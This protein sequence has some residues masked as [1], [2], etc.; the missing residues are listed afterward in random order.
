MVLRLK[1]LIFLNFS[2]KKIRVW[3]RLFGSLE[4]MMNQ[5]N[6][7]EIYSVFLSQPMHDVRT[8]L[9]GGWN[10]VKI[11]KR[12]RN[13]VFRTSSA[14]WDNLGV[15]IKHSYC[16]NKKSKNVMKTRECEISKIDQGFLQITNT[17]ILSL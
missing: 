17:L 3:A 12:R 2:K 8:T 9:H 7:I 16:M 10:D 15:Q 11:L 14:G 6:V 4:Y 1:F 13:N 5:E